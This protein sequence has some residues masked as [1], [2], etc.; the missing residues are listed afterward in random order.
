MVESALR[1]WP[2]TVG[3]TADGNTLCCQP[4]QHS[5]PSHSFFPRA[6]P[7]A[8]LSYKKA[9]FVVRPSANSLGCGKGSWMLQA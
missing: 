5:F 7:A 8:T 6:Q 2:S 4:L 1:S 3:V 9:V